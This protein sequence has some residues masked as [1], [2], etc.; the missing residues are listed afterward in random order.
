VSL[1]ICTYL[2]GAK[3]GDEILI[4][5]NMVKTGKSMAFFEVEIRNKISGDI[6]V[7]GKQSQFLVQ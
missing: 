6:L 5:A 4:N 1:L 2:K 7:K 3:V